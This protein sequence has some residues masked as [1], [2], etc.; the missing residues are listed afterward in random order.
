MSGL[1]NVEIPIAQ[2]LVTVDRIGQNELAD[3]PLLRDSFLAG[4]KN[5]VVDSTLTGTRS[6]GVSWVGSPILNLSG[7]VNLI[8]RSVDQL[9]T[10]GGT[11][12]LSGNEV[13]TARGSS[14][15]LNGGYVHVDG[16]IV[17][18]TRLVDANG[19][20]VPIG[21]ASQYETYV[22][23]AGQFIENHP[24][25][26]V[27]KTWYN[28]LL[29]GG[30]YQ[31]D[32]IVGGNAGTLDLFATSA[33]VLD[34]NISAQSFGG[35]KQMQG[36]SLPAG[37]TF[38]LGA[39]A[40]LTSGTLAG[41]TWSNSNAAPTGVTGLTILQGQAPQL[42]DLAPG[43]SSNTPI[44]K[45]SLQNVAATDPHNVLTTMVVP[46]DVL[47][48]GGFSNVNVTQ[49]THGGK[50]IVV[51]QDTHLDVQPGGAIALNSATG[52]ADVNVLGSLS[53]PGGSISI[54][55][56]GNIIVGPQA[57]LGAA[58]QWVNNDGQ[59]APGTTPG[60]TQFIN[61]GTISLSTT[62]QSV[63]HVGDG[64]A[65]ST[66]SIL[67]RPGSV[68]DVSSGGELQS[69]GQ[70]LM[71]NG[72]PVGRGGNVSLQTY[73]ALETKQFGHIR[74]TGPDMPTT[75]PANGTIEL[76][77]TILSDGF[78]G[79]GTLTLQALGFQIGGDRKTAAPWDVYLPENFFAARFRQ[80]CPE[81]LLRRDRRAGA[82]VALTQRNLI[83]DVLALQQATTGANLSTAGL[84]ASGRLD[85]YH[86]QPTSLV[87]TGGNYVSWLAAGIRYRRIRA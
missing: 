56:G 19:A 49:D 76:G 72:T 74:D 31:G 36:N 37:G 79:G 84:T 6:D 57:V 4:L 70:L 12:T 3:S 83:P 60:N 10:N 58:G 33:L 51:A 34:G 11:I 59:A 1:A 86:R 48:A 14:L 44:D 62:E 53:A 29:T 18:T 27:T 61:G 80:V 40:K 32:Y 9:L 13:M 69:N 21:Q 73:V 50:G 47:N 64:F 65:D 75:Q 25:W 23:I 16:G 82:T 45:T 15:N 28:P 85:D 2:T 5:V 17:N 22:G 78:S 43:F 54:A 77:G 52:G 81:C 26:G 42:D 24:R 68:L 38:N 39:D 41:L 8:P 87:L 67:L 63:G 7:Y 66:G 35:A 46:V 71:Q 55:S 30:S 20:I